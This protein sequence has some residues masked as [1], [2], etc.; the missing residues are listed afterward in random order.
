MHASC[1]FTGKHCVYHAMPFDPALALEYL[2]DDM[3]SE[4]GLAARSGSGM[5]LVLSGF[6]RHFYA[7]RRESLGQLFGDDIAYSHAMRLAVPQFGVNIVR[8]CASPVVKT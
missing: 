6:I 7:Q 8:G 2:R 5:P 3:N 1:K 4:M